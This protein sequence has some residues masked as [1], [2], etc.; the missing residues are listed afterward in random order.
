[1]EPAGLFSWAPASYVVASLPALD[2]VDADRH[3][4]RLRLHDTITCDV[5]VG[6]TVRLTYLPQ[7]DA[8]GYGTHDVAWG[9][10]LGCFSVLNFRTDA[11]GKR[12]VIGGDGWV[13]TVE[14]VDVLRAY[15]MLAYGES[16][17][18][19]SPHHSDQAE[20]FARGDMKRVAFTERDIEAQTIRRYRPGMVT[21]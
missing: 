15:S 20:V 2:A 13:L 11:D 14:F 6:A 4:R 16:T 19:Q 1:M 3:E 5:D 21:P 10:A 12:P 18:E 7:N 8:R 9:G 17:R